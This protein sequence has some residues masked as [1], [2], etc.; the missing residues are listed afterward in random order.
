MHPLSPPTLELAWSKVMSLLQHGGWFALDDPRWLPLPRSQRPPALHALA[1]MG[2]PLQFDQARGVRAWPYRPTG[3][4]R[5]EAMGRAHHLLFPLEIIFALDSTNEELLRRLRSGFDHPLALAAEAQLKGRGRRNRVWLSALGAGITLSLLWPGSVSNYGE[6]LPLR[7][8]VAV[9]DALRMLGVRRVGLKWPND[10]VAPGG[11]L[12]GIL[13]ETRA[14]GV[15]IGLGLNHERLPDLAL[16]AG[17]SVTSIRELAGRLAPPRWRV[18]EVV[19]QAL[20]RVWRGED[21]H[22]WRQRFAQLDVLAG[23]EVTVLEADGTRRRGVAE[24][25]DANGALQVRYDEGLSTVVSAEVSV[26]V[27]P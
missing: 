8:G 3:L 22:T 16:R 19:L 2:A 1:Q 23:R 12:G 18:I 5:P 10:L 7:V 17:R 14:M 25:I 20:A 4:R 13:V 27:S 6:A 11:K 15:V 26:M 21:A 24:G 9:A